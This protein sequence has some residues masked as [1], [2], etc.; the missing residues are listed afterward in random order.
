M[1]WDASRQNEKRSSRVYKDLNLN[2]STNPVTQD[3]TT[4]TD[5]NAVKRSVR[6]L[7]LTNHY[8]RPFH[9]EI[10]SN[11]QALLFEN[12]GPITGNQLT[13]TIEEMI[14]NFEPRARVES[15]ECFPLPDT[16]TYDIR[17]YF[18]VE[19][20]PAEL[21]EFQTLLEAMR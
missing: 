14:A 8:D 18:Y 3:V 6:N 13:R 7:L 16:N 12:F 20:M 19:N 11:V 9:P 21:I 10:G 4:V 2:F 1:A 5:V 15:V 17:I